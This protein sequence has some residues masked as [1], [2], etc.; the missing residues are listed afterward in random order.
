MKHISSAP[1]LRRHGKVSDDIVVVDSG[2]TDGTQQI[3]TASGARLI[4][5]T[6]GMV[7]G[8]I[9]TKALQRP[10][11]DWILSID[12]DEII[13][14]MLI[15][16]LKSLVFTDT[17]IVYN[18]RFRAFFGDKMIRFGEWAKEEHIRLYNRRVVNWD[19]AQVH[20]SLQLPEITELIT[21]N[22][23]IHHYTSRNLQELAAKTLH[24]AMLNAAKYHRQGKKAGWLRCR[25]SGPFHSLSITSCGSDFLDGEAG[26]TIAKMNAW[27][28]WMKYTELRE[29]NKGRCGNL[30]RWNE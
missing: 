2:S 29:L 16:E 20:E 13:D 15:H 10:K 5:T 30:K 11:H 1:P 26:Y 23:Y 18:L 12:A 17:S 8:P 7:T 6:D 3:V 21:L 24:Y 28:T 4:E 27:Y 14:E 22:G 25:L 19:T 9:K